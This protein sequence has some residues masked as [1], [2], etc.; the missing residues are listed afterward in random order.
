MLSISPNRIPQV[1]CW[2]GQ[3]FPTSN[4]LQKRMWWCFSAVILDNKQA[5]EFDLGR[6]N[7]DNG[8]PSQLR[9]MNL[10]WIKID[11]TRLALHVREDLTAATWV[12]SRRTEPKRLA[13]TNKWTEQILDVAKYMY[14]PSV[15]TRNQ[16]A[17]GMPC[18]KFPKKTLELASVTI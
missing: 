4:W 18:L 3:P 10:C 11:C 17:S 12:N 16:R 9:M 15:A 2:S 13:R 5:R 8:P 7:A 14:I 6:W 1:F